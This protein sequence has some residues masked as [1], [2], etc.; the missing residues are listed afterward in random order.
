MEKFYKFLEIQ[1]GYLD[2]MRVF[3]KP[4]KLQHMIT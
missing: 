3:K 4:L 1:Y 2:S